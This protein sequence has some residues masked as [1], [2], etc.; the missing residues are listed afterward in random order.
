MKTKIKTK[1]FDCV[2]MKH[3]AQQRIRKELANLTRAEELAYWQRIVEQDRLRRE[4][5]R[6]NSG[7]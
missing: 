3:Q 1:T 4:A 5:E 6:G 2:E 7:E